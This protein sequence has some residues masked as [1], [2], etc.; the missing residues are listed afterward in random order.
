MVLVLAV[1]TRTAANKTIN[2]S[3][4]CSRETKK[5]SK[6]QLWLRDYNANIEL[7]KVIVGAAEFIWHCCLPLV[8]SARLKTVSPHY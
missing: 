3:F 8:T 4:C 6:P 2:Y 7:A 5:N 1:E